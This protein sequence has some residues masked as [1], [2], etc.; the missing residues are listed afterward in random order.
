MQVYVMN[1]FINAKLKLITHNEQDCFFSSVP[2]SQLNT[3]RGNQS[4][5]F[6]KVN[7][8]TYTTHLTHANLDLQKPL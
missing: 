5:V 7:I 8:L 4:G 6:S 1:I 3:A 2:A